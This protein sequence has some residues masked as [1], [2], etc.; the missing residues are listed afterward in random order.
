MSEKHT[1]NNMKQAPPQK[2]EWK[3]NFI[4]MVMKQNNVQQDL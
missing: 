2:E 4:I 3:Q 1:Q